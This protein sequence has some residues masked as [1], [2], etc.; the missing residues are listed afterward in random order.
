V[1]IWNRIGDVAF[2]AAKNTVK[3]GGELANAV[4][5]TARFAWD[6]GTAPWNDA[7]QYNGF[8]QTFKTAAAKNAPDIVKPLSS[9]GGA[10][11]KVPGV[12]PALER[13]NYINREYIRE[14]LTTYNL[15]LGDI[16]SGRESIS[17][18]FNPKEWSKAYTAAQDIS[19]GQ[20]VV[21]TFRN[22]YDPKFNIYDPKEREQAFKKS[23]WGKALSGSFDRGIQFIGDVS[24]GPGKAVKVLKASQLGQGALKN[25]DVVAKAAEDITKAQAGEVNR[26]TKVLDDFTANDSVYALNHP[27]VK[28]SSQP[29]LLAHLLGDS[30]DREETAL[31]LRSAMS[32]PVAMDQLREQRRYITDALEA[33]RGDLSSVDEWKLF[34]APD[35]SG[36]LPFLNDNIAVAEDALANY[37]SLA[38]HDKYFSKLMGLGEGGGA[39]TRTTGFL[40]KV[41]KI[42]LQKVVLLVFMT[43]QLVILV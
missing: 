3:F 35:G 29:G 5:G 23:A 1:S 4:G 13:I 37:A 9:A 14:P 7:K 25:A 20:A 22:A 34:S 30:V 12:Q 28:S 27:M 11:M 33:G 6:I 8:I 26:F 38:E 19:Y 17:E 24:L 39:L 36:M 32:D 15:V 16:T 10:I 2:T 41:L 21:G 40:V 42:L 31:I 18:V 43:S